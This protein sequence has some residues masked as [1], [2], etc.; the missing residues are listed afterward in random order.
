MHKEK[1]KASVS[2]LCLCVQDDFGYS[3]EP[4]DLGY[5]KEDEADDKPFVHSDD[6]L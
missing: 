3:K 6:E 2:Y 4:I 5:S 1:V